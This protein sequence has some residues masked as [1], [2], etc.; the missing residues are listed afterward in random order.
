M[1]IKDANARIEAQ[2]RIL[3]CLTVLVGILISV[4]WLPPFVALFTRS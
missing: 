3:I 1:K 2:L 4:I